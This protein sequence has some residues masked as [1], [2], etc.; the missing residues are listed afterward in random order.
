MGV[1]VVDPILSLMHPASA[2]VALKPYS[3]LVLLQNLASVCLFIPSNIAASMGFPNIFV[4]GL[5][6]TILLLLPNGLASG[7][8]F[9]RSP[10]Q[11]SA[12]LSR[13][14]TYIGQVSTIQTNNRV[15]YMIVAGAD[16]G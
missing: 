5:A 16:W 12:P 4:V 3:L 8:A 13:K 9:S 7:L 15:S 14:E 2:S 6:T 10:F 11:F 1:N